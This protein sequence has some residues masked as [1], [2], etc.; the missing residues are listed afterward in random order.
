M[1]NTQVKKHR[2]CCGDRTAKNPLFVIA[3]VLLVPVVICLS[4]LLIPIFILSVLKQF[5]D[6]VSKMKKMQE[7][8]KSNLEAHRA[9]RKNGTRTSS[10]NDIPPAK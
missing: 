7:S 6:H 10:S 8:M 3:A 9:R 5:K 1:T 2:G 4:P